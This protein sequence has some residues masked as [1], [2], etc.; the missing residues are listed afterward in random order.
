MKLWMASEIHK[1]TESCTVDEKIVVLYSEAQ[2][3]IDNLLTEKHETEIVVAGIVQERDRARAEI[4]RLRA[5][6]DMQRSLASDSLTMLA[7]EAEKTRK[8]HDLLR[9]ARKAII[10][11]PNELTPEDS[12]L[13]ARIRALIGG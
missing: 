2:A 13:V 1:M 11:G 6:L 7:D 4:D 12:E 3:E 9:E 5:E 8:A 10:S